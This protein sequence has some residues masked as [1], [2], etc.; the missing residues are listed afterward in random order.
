M[1]D[2]VNEVLKQLDRSETHDVYL[3]PSGFWIDDQFVERRVRRC[4]THPFYCI[5]ETTFWT[6]DDST[7]V[8]T[9][10]RTIVTFRDPVIATQCLLQ[11]IPDAC[12]RSFYLHVNDHR[13][14]RFTNVEDAVRAMNNVVMATPI[15]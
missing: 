12:T 9:P 13:V 6:D 11:G 10:V 5:E 7:Y 2:L 4:N 15:R 14:A 8:Q 1:Q 3:V